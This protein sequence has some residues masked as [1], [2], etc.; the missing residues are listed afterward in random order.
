MQ[1]IDFGAEAGFSDNRFGSKGFTMTPL[2]RDA[3][4]VVCVRVAAGGRIGRHPAVAHQV[5]ALVE[6]EGVAI[7][8]DGVE[9]RVRAGQAVVWGPGEEHETRTT[10]GLTAVVV[11]GSRPLRR[12]S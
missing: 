5:F 10:Q 9:Q 4:N 6:G 2:V 1:I 3:D 7:G 8:I 12:V 11:E